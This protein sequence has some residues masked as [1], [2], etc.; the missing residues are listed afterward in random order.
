MRSAPP[1]V[2]NSD[3]F[4]GKRFFNPGDPQ[5]K[6]FF[7]FLRWR[8]TGDRSRWPERVENPPQPAPP[9]PADL[10]PGDVA[11][12]FINHATV[13]LQTRKSA[14]L[15]DPVYSERAS[16]VGFAGPKRVRDP[17]IPF[18]RLPRIDAVL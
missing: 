1:P 3:H 12:T 6:G 8:L 11:V 14:L 13:L 16:P 5:P 7:S 4:D 2:Q 15:T 10:A 18:D 9:D 17:G